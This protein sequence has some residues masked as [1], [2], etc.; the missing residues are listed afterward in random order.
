MPPYWQSPPKDIDAAPNDPKVIRVEAK[1][2]DANMR[3]R[4][5]CN[6]GQRSQQNEINSPL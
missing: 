3:A 1:P 2:N 6:A 4:L 5:P